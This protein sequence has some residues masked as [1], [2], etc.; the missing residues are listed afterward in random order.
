[1][2]CQFCQQI[3]DDYFGGKLSG[4]MRS[5]VEAHLQ[6]CEDCTESYNLLSFAEKV[7]ESEKEIDPDQFLTARIMAG[8]EAHEESA[9]KI[10]SPFKRILRPALIATALAAA[11]FAGVMIGNLYMPSTRVLSKPVEFALIDDI[12]IEAV[13]VLSNE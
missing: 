12:T 8:I 13:D 5:K 2:N 7:I 3:S 11:V 1:M 6:N 10:S 4:D 9:R